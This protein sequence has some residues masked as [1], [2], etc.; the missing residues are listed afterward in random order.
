MF[1]LVNGSPFNEFILQR[2]LGV[3]RVATKALRLEKIL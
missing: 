3:R 1:V 2:G